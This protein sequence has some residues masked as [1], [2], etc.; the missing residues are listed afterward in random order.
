MDPRTDRQANRTQ[1]LRSGSCCTRCGKARRIPEVQ[2][3][4]GSDRRRARAR[5]VM[6][7]SV[8]AQHVARSRPV[9]G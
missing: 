1:T 6:L 9:D 8:E 2:G 5:S 3:R 7:A 4:E